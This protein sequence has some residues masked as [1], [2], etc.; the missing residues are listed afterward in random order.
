MITAEFLCYRKLAIDSLEIKPGITTIIG[1]NGSGKT[2]FLKLCAGIAVP[3]SGT[4]LIDDTPPRET[5]IGWVNEFPDRNIL[6]VNVFDEIASPL[7]F[8]RIPC[9][10]IDSKVRACA[11]TLGITCLLKR[12]VRDLSGGEKVLVS[13]AAAMVHHPKVLVLDEYDSHLDAHFMAKI[14]QGIRRSGAEY[15]IRC[16]QQMDT[17]ICSDHLLFFDSGRITHAGPPHDIFPF[18]KG[19]AYYPLLWGC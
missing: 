4:L 3:D 11:E 1:A 15:V 9:D 14:E 6:F 8:R 5:E 12:E 7:R 2:T 13:L 10:E 18:L 17:A 16:T 19:T